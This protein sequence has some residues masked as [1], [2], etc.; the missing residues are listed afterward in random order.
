MGTLAAFGAHFLVFGLGRAF[1]FEPIM[2]LVKY[3][4]S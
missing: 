4:S 1:V 3:A 2:E